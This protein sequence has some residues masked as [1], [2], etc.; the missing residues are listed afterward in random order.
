VNHMKATRNSMNGCSCGAPK[1]ALGL[2]RSVEKLKVRSPASAGAGGK[3][4]G[5]RSR[6]SSSH[7]VEEA[8]SRL[9]VPAIWLQP[10]AWRRAHGSAE[11]VRRREGKRGKGEDPSM[12][13]SH[14]R[15]G[16]A[17][18]DRPARFSSQCR[19]QNKNVDNDPSTYI[20][21]GP[22]QSASS[23]VGQ[24]ENSHRIAAARRSS[25]E[26]ASF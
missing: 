25:L 1:L 16:V 26:V 17:S 23:F 5:K 20:K 24:K 4:G 11:E 6:S 19:H 18:K 12:A 7:S 14:F 3:S 2:D 9:D 13:K 15:G 21:R 8:S 22:L 10:L